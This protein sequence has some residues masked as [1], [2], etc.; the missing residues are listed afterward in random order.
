MYKIE[1]VEVDLIGYEGPLC[2]Q[3][4]AEYI[5]N[6]VARIIAK[7]IDTLEDAG[8]DDSLNAFL[9]DH[10]GNTLT[11][12]LG[13]STKRVKTIDNVRLENT[14]FVKSDELIEDMWIPIYRPFRQFEHYPQYLGHSEFN[15]L[16]DSDIVELPASM[17]ALGMKNGG[18][19]IYHET[20]NQYPWDYEIKYTIDFIISM[21]FSRTPCVPPPTFYCV[22]C[23]LDGYIEH[24]YP[25]P[26]RS[27]PKRVG[28]IE[29]RNKSLI[30]VTNFHYNEY[31][32]FHSK[33]TILGQS[34]RAHIPFSIPVV[35]RYYLYLNRYNLYRS[36]HSG[37]PFST[38]KPRLVYAGNDR[39]SKYN[40]MTRRD[41]TI[42]QRAYFSSDK[43]DKT[44]V[45]TGSI[46]REEMIGYKYILDIDGNACT[47]DATAWKLNS[48]S[49]IF[50]TD[51]DWKQWFYNEYIPWVH[52]V[53]IKEDFVDIQEKIEW[54]EN[55]QDKCE[56][57]VKKCKLL[58]QT[59]YRHDNVVKHTASTILSLCE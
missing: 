51:T 35:D 28:D 14:T 21:M 23:A 45:D 11:I 53:P 19:F 38:K 16:F 48:G 58:F 37:I 46:S 32:I 52:Y 15:S 27:I 59:I 2:V 4:V 40:F 26:N 25:S 7:R 17:F 9:H 3:V 30:D 55:N 44:N 5:D 13:K 49:V 41:I 50:K 56:E 54:C 33:K 39:G 43:V 10:Q 12:P 8:W 57:M 42:S 18:A 47:W 29:Y 22:I 1:N 36:I 20:Y 24:C 34:T 31:P 6:N